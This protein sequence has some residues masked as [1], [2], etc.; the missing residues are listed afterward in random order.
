M[1]VISDEDLASDQSG[2]PLQGLT[3]C[4]V[5]MESG[6]L[7]SDKKNYCSDSKSGPQ[8]SLRKIS[9]KPPIPMRLCQSKFGRI[10]AKVR[11]LQEHVH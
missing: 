5:A 9:M 8:P 1:E 6:V 3:V 4:H 11:A 2:N 10:R 7:S